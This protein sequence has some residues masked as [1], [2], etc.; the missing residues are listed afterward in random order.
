MKKSLLIVPK[1]HDKVCAKVVGLRRKLRELNKLIQAKRV[2]L[3][4]ARAMSAS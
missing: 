1:G 2:R 4:T 3:L